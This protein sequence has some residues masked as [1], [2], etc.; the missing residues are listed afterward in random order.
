MQSSLYLNKRGEQQDPDKM[1]TAF[2]LTTVY[3]NTYKI[4]P[5]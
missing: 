4:Y 3:G 5:K 2:Y 1:S